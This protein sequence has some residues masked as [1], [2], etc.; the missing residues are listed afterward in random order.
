MTMPSSNEPRPCSRAPTKNMATRASSYRV[1]K[2]A[3][4]TCPYA[5]MSDQRTGTS[6]EN[7]SFDGFSP[8]FVPP[9][10]SV[11]GEL[12]VGHPVRPGGVRPETIDLVLLV[13]L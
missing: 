4:L 11:T 2:R 7:R 1:R 12:A 13:R 9:D 6:Y 8:G 5:S 3:L 10:N